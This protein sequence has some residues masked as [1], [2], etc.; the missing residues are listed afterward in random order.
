MINPYFYFGEKNIW[1]RGFKISD[2]GTELKNEFN[3]INSSIIHFKPL[4]YQGL[5]NNLPDM[6]SICFFT[7]IKDRKIIFTKN[8]PLIYQPGNFVPINSK[9][10]RYLYEIFPLLMFSLSLE[11][12][13]ADIWRG[14][15]IQYFAW[16]YNGYIVYHNTE[17]FQ[18]QIL[19]NRNNFIREKSNYFDLKELLNI[20]DSLEDLYNPLKLIA[21][22]IS[23]KILKEIYMEVYEA[24]LNDLKDIGYEF[25]SNFSYKQKQNYL[26]FIKVNSIQNIYLPTSMTLAKNNKIKIIEHKYSKNL[27]ND[28]LLI[29]NYNH[30]EFIKL[31]GYLKKLYSQ[32][33]PNMISINPSSEN[34]GENSISCNESYHGY[35]SYKCF[36]NI[37]YKYPFYKGYLFINDD[38]FMKPWEL[39][40]LDFDIPWIY[41]LEPMRK[42]WCKHWNCE[43]LFELI[44]NNSDWKSNIIKFFGFYS[45]YI[46]LS[47]FYY[48]PNFYASK[49]C[50]LIKTMFN[51]RLFLECAVPTSFILL[52]SPKYQIIYYKGFWNE[53]RN[54]A[55]YNLYNHSKEI[56]IH[57]IKF[58]NLYFQN[59]VNDYI[60]FTNAKYF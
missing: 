29:I 27:Y 55:L 7:R 22:L 54:K 23:K 4:I 11:E 34:K 44:K 40:N 14:Y 13:I 2:L 58:S 45:I 39:E 36:S 33:F 38:D 18:N 3:L 43:I 35:Y 60:Y 10:T 49:F 30:A 53:D 16:K 15:I 47:D 28:I 9:N 5:I 8:Y 50:N 17:I 25:S 41:E 20:L 32:Y 52:S 46:T 1:P 56:T 51:T 48:L 59:K 26:N 24:Y 12:N 57:P 19:Y 21:L 42:D 31:N 6:D 37:Y